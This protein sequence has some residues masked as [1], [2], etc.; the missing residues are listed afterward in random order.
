[1]SQDETMKCRPEVRNKAKTPTSKQPMKRNEHLTREP[2][3]HR[4]PKGRKP[5]NYN[6]FKVQL[7][8]KSH[9][10]SIKL[11]NSTLQQPISFRHP[12]PNSN[13]MAIK[14]D[15]LYDFAEVSK[16]PKAGKFA[17][18][19]TQ[20][21]K[22]LKRIITAVKERGD[23]EP[24][25]SDLLATLNLTKKILT[26]QTREL[27]YRSSGRLSFKGNVEPKA[28]LCCEL[29]P[30]R[31]R[32][33]YITEKRYLE[34]EQ[35]HS[36]GRS[37][38]KETTGTLMDQLA[39]ELLSSIAPPEQIPTQDPIIS[40][41]GYISTPNH[42]SDISPPSGSSNPSP[43]KLIIRKNKSKSK[44]S[45]KK[46]NN[47]KQAL[48]KIIN[49]STITIPSITNPEELEAS[50]KTIL[51]NYLI[52]LARELGNKPQTTPSNTPQTEPDWPVANYEPVENDNQQTEIRSHQSRNGKLKLKFFHQVELPDGRIKHTSEDIELAKAIEQWPTETRAYFRKL[53]GKPKS[54]NPIFNVYKDLIK[55]II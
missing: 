54:F 1:M 19:K 48:K 17:E 49:Q 25:S 3:Q 18:F 43:I 32:I 15:C 46:M 51:S 27:N 36:Q 33:N 14:C 31:E 29:K 44:K 53:E 7:L 30:Y 26:D 4:C 52:T 38:E 35:L 24:L 50:E 37:T 39:N 22:N 23:K 10:K 21:D 2:N 34:E 40:E 5:I 47:L 8:N 42:V 6:S 41:S 28:H 16:G 55:L 45:T 9:Q 12:T 11:F 13:I 20:V